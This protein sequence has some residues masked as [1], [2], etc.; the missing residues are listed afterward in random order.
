MSRRFEDKA[1]YE[2]FTI[3][4]E[5]YESFLNGNRREFINFLHS[6]DGDEVYKFIKWLQAENLKI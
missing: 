1:D 3:F 2:I 5:E 6:L 4:S